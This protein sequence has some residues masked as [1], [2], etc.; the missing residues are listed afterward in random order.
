M[1]EIKNICDPAMYV[2][3]FSKEKFSF[4][5]GE[6]FTFKK[7]MGTDNKNELLTSINKNIKQSPE[8]E[9]NKYN[10]NNQ[11]SDIKLIGDENKN[12]I[13]LIKNN[14]NT[15]INY[16]Q[17]SNNDTNNQLNHSKS[18]IFNLTSPNIQNKINSNEE[19]RNFNLSAQNNNNI[20]MNR[21]NLE[22]G[23]IRN[24]EIDDIKLKN[25]EL[26]LY[27]KLNDIS[28]FTVNKFNND[29]NEDEMTIKKSFVSY[30]L[31]QSNSIY[32]NLI[33]QKS[34]I[35]DFNGSKNNETFRIEYNIPNDEDIN[36]IVN[37][38]ISKN[39]TMFD[40]TYVFPKNLNNITLNQSHYKKE[41]DH[42]KSLRIKDKDEIT[43]DINSFDNKSFNPSSECNSA[44][45][46]EE[47][48]KENEFFDITD[49]IEPEEEVMDE[50]ENVYKSD[51]KSVISSKIMSHINTP[52]MLTDIK[53]STENSF[54]FSN[55]N[56]SEYF[57]RYENN[58]IGNSYYHSKIH[59]DSDDYECE[60]MQENTE[61]YNNFI[62][63]PKSS[64]LSI[65]KNNSGSL[66]RDNSYPKN[67]TTSYNFNHP[68]LKDLN[69]R[70]SHKEKEMKKINAKINQVMSDLL[71]YEEENKKYEKKIKEEEAEG[72]ILRHFLNFLTTHA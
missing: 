56:K 66:Y 51:N 58:Q 13:G 35:I 7:S 14:R 39:N 11:S 45:F 18:N 8:I 15:N 32:S 37:K 50:R 61:G 43:I 71:K 21:N 9:I 28:S 31:K 57:N 26:N 69:D 47:N 25:K 49:E 6:D 16:N 68:H 41:E 34:S 46:K 1:P 40:S 53:T 19:I 42:S 52:K 64:H 65:L 54:A 36:E 55:F 10:Y 67:L 29:K 62:D 70:L 17:N 63:T 38:S 44:S 20:S 60:I 22:E 72:Q 24:K 33:N 27:K 48:K 5:D 3:N 4:K 2:S 59:P 12:D 23:F 30:N